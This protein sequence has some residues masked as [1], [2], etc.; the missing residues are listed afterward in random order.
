MGLGV[1]AR[2]GRGLGGILLVHRAAAHCVGLACQQQNAQSYAMS[3]QR[4]HLAET[5]LNRRLFHVYQCAG[6]ALSQQ[7]QRTSRQDTKAIH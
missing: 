7:H 5:V 2:Y 4:S 6:T 3:R 1:R